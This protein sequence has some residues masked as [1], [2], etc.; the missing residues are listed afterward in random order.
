MRRSPDVNVLAWLRTCT[1]DDLCLSVIT[2]GELGKGFVRLDPT[3][4]R[5]AMLIRKYDELLLRFADRIL[6]IDQA[7]AVTWGR[8]MGN[9]DK[10]GERL[11]AIDALIASTALAND[12]SVVTRNVS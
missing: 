7:V 8:L 5:Y 6:P 1:D 9:A 11:P 3:D 2:V 4:D 10:S 12:L